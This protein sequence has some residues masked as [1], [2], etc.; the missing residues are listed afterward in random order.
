MLY[1]LVKYMQ[2]YNVEMTVIALKNSPVSNTRDFSLLN[3]NVIV[4]NRGSFKENIY[5]CQKLIDYE[6]PNIVHS[7]G[8][9]ADFVNSKLKGKFISYSTIHCD[10]DEDFAMKLGKIKGWLKA[11]AF[12]TSIKKIDKPIAC[13]ET[14]ANKIHEKR[15]LNL[16]YIRNGI[17]LERM[18][19]IKCSVTRK[20]LGISEDA[21][22]LIFCGYLSKRKNVKYICEAI[23]KASR[24]DI[25][26]LILGDGEEFTHISEENRDCDRI[27]MVGRVSNPFAYYMISDVFISASLSEGLPLAVMEGMGCGLKAML[28]NIDSHQE[29]KKCCNGGVELFDLEQLDEL[30]QDIETLEHKAVHE[31][32]QEARKTVLNYLNAKRMAQEYYEMYSK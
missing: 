15:G 13:S 4:L 24:K 26:L 8:G 11:T 25:C 6:N 7:H 9:V 3:C 31:K 10:P 12:I 21:M 28:S 18:N 19:I 30:V 20:D 23:K 1:T 16:C 5:E 29:M 27:K 14:V 22:V 17:D 32:G 2:M